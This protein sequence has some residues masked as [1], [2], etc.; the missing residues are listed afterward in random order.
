M[1]KENPREW[2]RERYCKFC[3][4]KECQQKGMGIYYPGKEDLLPC[5]LA[6]LIMLQ[7]E[8]NEV[9]SYRKKSS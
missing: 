6:I 3:Q 9:A 2:F 7:T 5:M 1:R 4:R 8:R